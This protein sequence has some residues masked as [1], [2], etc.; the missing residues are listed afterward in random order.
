MHKEKRMLKAHI[1]KEQGH[2]QHEIAK[3]LGVTDRTVRNYLMSEPCHRKKRNYSSKLDSFKSF[4]QSILE[5]KPFYS[6]VLLIERLKKMGYN[7]QIS[8]L[9]DY[10]A[11]VRKKIITEAVIRFETEPGYQAQVDWK[12]FGKQRVEGKYQKLY[13]FLMGLGYSRNGFVYFTTSM[14]QSVFHGCHV[15]AFEY[16]GGVPREIVYDNMKTAFICDSDGNFYPNRKLL[17][18]SHHYGFTPRRCMVRRPQT[19]GKVERFIGYMAGN[20]WPEVE[21]ED[22]TLDYLNEKV[23]VWLKEVNKKPV[24]GLL[25]S[26]Y[27]RFSLEKPHLQSLPVFSY[28]SR[29]IHEVYVSR[30]SYIT[31]ETNRYSVPP[32]FIGERLTLKVDY[33]IFAGELYNGERSIRKFKLK[34]K[35]N[36]ETVTLPEDKSAILK[37]WEKQRMKRLRREFARNKV[38]RSERDIETRDPSFYERIMGATV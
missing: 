20:F 27:E 24:G 18:F 16:F 2:K 4:I 21:G 33:M 38:R 5:D 7:G 32:E 1:L 8:I 29:D 34:E 28:D 36:R 23:M 11:K 19:K 9:R 10:A 17:G 22:L 31:F 12:D 37:L 6:C 15:K 35:G 26:R 25:E 30:E 3:M 14:R 13:A